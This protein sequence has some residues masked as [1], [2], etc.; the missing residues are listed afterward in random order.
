MSIS[1]ATPADGS[2]LTGPPMSDVFRMMT[3][4]GAVAI[5]FGVLR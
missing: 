4:R 2:V 5:V 1:S 3:V